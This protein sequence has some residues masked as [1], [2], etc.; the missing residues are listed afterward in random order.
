MQLL[1][2]RTPVEYLPQLL[3]IIHVLRES[4]ALKPAAESFREGWREAMPGNV[5]GAVTLRPRRCWS[6]PAVVFGPDNGVR[7]RLLSDGS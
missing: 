1:M 6:V 2:R 4:V 7:P 3:Q 5:T